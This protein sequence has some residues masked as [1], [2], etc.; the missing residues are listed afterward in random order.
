MTPQRGKQVASF[1]GGPSQSKISHKRFGHLNYRDFKNSAAIE[2]ENTNETCD[3][4]RSAKTGRT[5]VPNEIKNR[6]W[7]RLELVFTDIVGPI[8]RS[9][10]DGFRYFVTFIDENSYH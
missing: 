1:G 4:C 3:T 2:L 7:K 9:S 5:P 6:E 8:T 10:V